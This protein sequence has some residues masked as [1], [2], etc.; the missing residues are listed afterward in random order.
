[1]VLKT[2]TK[3]NVWFDLCIRRLKVKSKNICAGFVLIMYKKNSKQQEANNW[4]AWKHPDEGN[5]SK[6]TIQGVYL[7]SNYSCTETPDI[8]SLTAPND[9]VQSASPDVISSNVCCTWACLL[10]DVICSISAVH[11]TRTLTQRA[12]RTFLQYVVRT[13]KFG[14]RWHIW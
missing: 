11:T 13:F 12:P 3:S 9:W 10:A 14:L 6:L 4:Y 2:Q 1:M 5:Q 7:L 8:F